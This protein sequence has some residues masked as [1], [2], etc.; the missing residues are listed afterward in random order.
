MTEILARALASQAVMVML[1][2]GAAAD[3]GRHRGALRKA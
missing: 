3:A 1:P 2:S